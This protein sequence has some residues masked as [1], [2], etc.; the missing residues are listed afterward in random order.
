MTSRILSLN[1]NVIY[2]LT[3]KSIQSKYIPSRG[4]QLF[5]GVRGTANLEVNGRKRKRVGG[6][7]RL[8]LSRSPLLSWGAFLIKHTSRKI[9]EGSRESYTKN[10]GKDDCWH[11]GWSQAPS[12]RHFAS[13]LQSLDPPQ[14][15]WESSWAQAQLMSLDVV[16]TQE[17]I[18]KRGL[19]FKFCSL[20]C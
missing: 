5:V 4:I 17:E 20:R 7:S 6:P 1:K 15:P 3:K 8:N 10:K 13:Y 14:Q 11:G 2:E 12:S 19:L 9:G 18:G 16:G